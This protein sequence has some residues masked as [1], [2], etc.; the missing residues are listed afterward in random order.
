VAINMMRL[1]ALNRLV[2]VDACQAEAIY[3]DPEVTDIQKWMEIGSRKARTS[4]LM[5]ARKGEP[6]L[7]VDPLKH[8]VFTYSLLRG[9]RAITD[10]EPKELARLKLP[11]DA[12]FDHD[13]TL[14]TG[15]LDNYVKQTMPLIAAQFPTMVAN[16]RDAENV[17]TA[18]LPANRLDQES[19]IQAVMTSFP[20]VPIREATTESP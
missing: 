20:L 15:E 7:E 14:T 2:I 9:M 17:G 10:T 3:S 11:A 16:R 18:T 12:D 8:G 4:Y 6:A 1:D 5:A 19:R 13:G